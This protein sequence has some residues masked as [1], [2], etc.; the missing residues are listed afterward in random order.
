MAHRRASHRMSE[1]ISILLVEDNE[2]DRKKVRRS[3]NASGLNFELTEAKDGASALEA[4]EKRHFDCVFLD[5]R[6]PDSDGAAIFTAMAALHD[7][8]PA[9]IFLTGLEDEEL[10]LQMMESGAVI[11]RTSSPAGCPIV[12]L[13]FLK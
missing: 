7:T 12:S 11:F 6:L 2:V 9:V 3:L 5:Y 8:K 10:A 1:K 13:I 4:C